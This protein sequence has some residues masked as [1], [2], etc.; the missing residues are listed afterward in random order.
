MS[1]EEVLASLPEEIRKEVESFGIKSF[2]DVFDFMLMNG[3]DPMKMM[4]C[5]EKGES[6]VRTSNGKMS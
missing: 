6:S 5:A 1:F 4:D 3:L 2:D